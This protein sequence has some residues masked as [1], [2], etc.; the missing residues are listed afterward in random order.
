MPQVTER[1]IENW[2]TF[3]PP[4]GQQQRQY[5]TIRAAAKILAL[6]IL[7]N[8]P[9]GP[10]QTTAIRKLRECVMVSNQAIA[11]AGIGAHAG[12]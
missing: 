7:H 2:F 6:E 8:T 11:L 4:A 9:E 1:D 10:D 5:E 3:H 12:G